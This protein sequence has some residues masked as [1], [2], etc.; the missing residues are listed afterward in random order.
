M[1]ST[2]KIVIVGCGGISN[3]WFHALK[4]IDEV[5]IVGLVDLNKASATQ[6]KQEHQ[7]AD[8][9]IG[10]DVE[11][12]LQDTRPD[13]VFDCTI[14]E[15]R[16]SVVQAA[17]RAGCH[18]LS[19]KPMATSLAEAHRFSPDRPGGRPSFCGDAKSPFRSPHPRL[20]PLPSPPGRWAI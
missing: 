13:I 4:K 2:S 8:A 14:P 12:M 18:V 20:A 11:A 19:E 17:L 1:T 15:A 7:L 10:T 9:A 5:A 3:C 16:A 6:K